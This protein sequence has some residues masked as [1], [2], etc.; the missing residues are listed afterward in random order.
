[1]KSPMPTSPPALTAQ[2]LA[3]LPWRVL[4]RLAFRLWPLK[5]VGTTLFITLFFMAYLEL[6]HNPA[7]LVTP[8]PIT[9]VDHWIGFQPQ[10]LGLYLSL[11]VYVSLPTVLLF[12]VRELVAFG[13]A[14][15]A[16]CLT[17]L[18]CFYFWPTSVPPIPVDWDAHPGFKLLQ[19]IDAAG[20][21]CPSLHVATAV[22][23]ALWLQILLLRVGASRML[24]VLNWLWCIGIVYST[25][26]IK[27][28]V[29]VDALAGTGLGLLFGLLSLRLI[30][31]DSLHQP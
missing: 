22:F 10:A 24:G 31:L 11:W 25:L 16:L 14:A 27:Q 6:L 28:H 26:A 18:A 8:M 5:M 9:R 30:R 17:G 7:G 23:S 15:A 2:H 20:N 29:F 1:M 4:L 12:S 21:A 19:G 13:W 3:T